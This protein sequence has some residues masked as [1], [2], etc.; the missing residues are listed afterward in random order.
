[1]N[2]TKILKNDKLSERK[3]KTEHAKVKRLAFY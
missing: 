2:I 1:M 3:N